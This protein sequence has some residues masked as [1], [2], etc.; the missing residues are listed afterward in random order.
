MDQ[1]TETYEQRRD[2]EERERQ[3]RAAA[4]KTLQAELPRLRVE[5]THWTTSNAEDN[6]RARR[7][8]RTLNVGVRVLVRDWET[9]R[10]LAESFG[11]GYL[12]EGGRNYWGYVHQAIEEAFAGAPWPCEVT[13]ESSGSL[14]TYGNEH[15]AG[16]DYYST[17]HVSA[18]YEV[19]KPSEIPSE[20]ELLSWLGGA[21][22]IAAHL[23]AAIDE[24]I[25][26]A[27]EAT[28]AVKRAHI[29]NLILDSYVERIDEAALIATRYKQRLAALNAEYKAEL[30]AQCTKLLADLGDEVDVEWEEP[31]FEPDPRSVTAAKAKLPEAVARLDVPNERGGFRLPSPGG[32]NFSLIKVSDVE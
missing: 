1:K 11:Y 8:N 12:A 25:E 31:D 10:R 29:G 32:M 19:A 13:Q 26:R 22:A 24:G 7:Y 3:Q 6:R 2:R 30:E 5:E 28:L 23:R 9:Q 18:T 15:D 4:R 27:K 14:R 17:F 20:G 21:E 16:W